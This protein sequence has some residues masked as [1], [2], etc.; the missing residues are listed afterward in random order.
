MT[1]WECFWTAP[2]GLARVSLRRF[3]YSSAG[4]PC[5]GP[6]GYHNAS[7]VIAD[8]V[9]TVHHDDGLIAAIDP[10]DYRDDPRWPTSCDACADVFRAE[11]AWQV[12]QDPIH[13]AADGRW[14]GVLRDA[15]PGAMWDAY[16]YPRKGPD[17]ICLVVRT[18]RGDGRPAGLGDDW[19]PD[20]RASNCTRPDDDAHYCWVR[21]GD[22]RA[23]PCTLTVDK[24]GDTCA[25]GA[26]SIAKP[27]WHGFLRAGRLVN[28]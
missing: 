4:R 15:P 23:I 22:P 25:A 8:G 12:N 9:P 17:G 13:L 27:T 2:S 19:M 26:G 18:P 16:W 5:P 21:H 24:D 14:S 28:A 1:E 3:V 7:V 6:A 20:L 10:A 11:D